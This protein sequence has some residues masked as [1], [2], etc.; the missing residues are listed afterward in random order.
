M[1]S[2]GF[3]VDFDFYT[4]VL[5]VP[6]GPIAFAAALAFKW[7]DSQPEKSH[8]GTF[9]TDFYEICDFPKSC[10]GFLT[11]YLSCFRSGCFQIN[12][13]EVFGRIQKD[14]RRKVMQVRGGVTSRSAFFALFMPI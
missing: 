3:S 8:M 4:A 1:G 13:F 14:A 9:P 2:T 5:G 7:L 11:W 12:I 6:S 10:R